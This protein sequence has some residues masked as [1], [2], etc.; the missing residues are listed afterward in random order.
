M[1]E[2]IERV[3]RA[4]AP[5]S[6]A[7]LGTGDT[8]AHKN[9]RT[10]STRHARLAI[11]AMREITDAMIDAAFDHPDQMDHQ[12]SDANAFERQ[13]KTAI[14]FIVVDTKAPA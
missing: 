6:W 11:A 7:A 4:L 5:T 12:Q 14:D 9:R 13:W 1:S 8:L 3:A 2:M 10:A